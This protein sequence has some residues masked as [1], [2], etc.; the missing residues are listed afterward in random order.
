M[1]TKVCNKCKIDKLKNEY[2]KDI[3]NKD[4]FKSVCKVCLSEYK[5][6]YKMANKAKINEYDIEYRKLNKTKTKEYEKGRYQKNKT[7]ISLYSK[8]YKTVN[9]E[10]DREKNNKSK[11]EYTK[12]R[13]KIDPLY[14]LNRNI[15]G[16]I[17]VSIKRRG[18]IKKS[19]TTDILGCTGEFFKA[20][21]ESQFLSWMNWGNHGLYNGLEGYGW[22]IDHIMPIS[23]A[24]TEQDVIRLNHYTNFQPLCSYKNR[25]VKKHLVD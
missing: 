25:Y 24:K 3:R 2:G 13:N 8:N 5:K 9:K 14:K 4:G 10:R 19:K 22:D 6:Q 11:R 18:Y 15:R 7:K 21:I 16:L 23:S 20:Y 1:E 12:K 17:S